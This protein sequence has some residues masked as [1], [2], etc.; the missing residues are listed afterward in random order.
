MG[1]YESHK[2]VT[3]EKEDYI[4]FGL[5]ENDG[6]AFST[7]KRLSTLYR[8]MGESYNVK[9]KTTVSLQLG[10]NNPDK[11]EA[12]SNIAYRSSQVNFDPDTKRFA[13]LYTGT[14]ALS[15]FE[16]TGLSSEIK[17]ICSSQLIKD[18][19]RYDV[20]NRFNEI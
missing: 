9:A 12:S 16:G 17:G 6:R 2:C 20:E 8:F 13:R 3:V 19:M 15:R 14:W 10:E 18:K 5:N 1:N 7:T 4:K 11:L